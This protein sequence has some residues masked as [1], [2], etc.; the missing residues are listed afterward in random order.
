MK[1]V[2]RDEVAAVVEA[3]GGDVLLAPEPGRALR[4]ARIPERRALLVF[5][6]LGHAAGTPPKRGVPC[7]SPPP[8]APPGKTRTG[9]FARQRAQAEMTAWR[10]ARAPGPKRHRGTP[11][12]PAS[13]RPAW[14]VGSS[15]ALRVP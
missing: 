9:A 13:A 6:S 12:D 3:V 1:G 10:A 4:Q 7:S 2:H 8:S 14:N 11:K 15:S 5:A